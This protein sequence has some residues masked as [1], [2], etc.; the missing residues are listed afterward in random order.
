[1][2]ARLVLA[3]QIAIIYLK[4]FTVTQVLAVNAKLVTIMG[5]PLRQPLSAQVL[6]QG[7]HAQ[8]ALLTQTAVIYLQLPTVIQVPVVLAK[9]VTIV[10]VY[11]R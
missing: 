11:P 7:T 8:L 1:M 9:L 4:Q 3:I 10:D 6:A 2:N 5:V